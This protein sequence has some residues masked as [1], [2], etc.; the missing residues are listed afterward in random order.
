MDYNHYDCHNITG[1]GHGANWL[2]DP[3][4]YTRMSD[5]WT[6]PNFRPAS[7][8]RARARPSCGVVGLMCR[9]PWGGSTYD[10]D[11]SGSTARFHPGKQA[12]YYCGMPAPWEDDN[13]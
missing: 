1:I 6:R 9:R 13:F 3:R 10:G 2:N 5:P 7:M 4:Y 8:S 12:R 11:K